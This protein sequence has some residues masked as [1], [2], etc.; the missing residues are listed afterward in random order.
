M[1]YGTAVAFAPDASALLSVSSDASAV[2][3]PLRGAGGSGGG[4]GTL[5]LAMA[6]LALLVALLAALVGALRY[7][8]A[9]QQLDLGALPGWVPPELIRLVLGL[10]A[11]G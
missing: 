9:A 7:A 11:G 8:A 4:G 5:G 2:V 1:V 3:V 10:P 6:L